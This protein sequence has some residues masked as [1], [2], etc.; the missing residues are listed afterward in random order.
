MLDHALQCLALAR[1][2]SVVPEPAKAQRRVNATL[3][4][5]LYARTRLDFAERHAS[6]VTLAGLATFTTVLLGPAA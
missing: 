4:G 2:R 5:D 6:V 3:G 1:G